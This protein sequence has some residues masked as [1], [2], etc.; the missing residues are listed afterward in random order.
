MRKLLPQV[1]EVSKIDSTV[2]L[3]LRVD[4]DIEY[5]KGHF[6]GFAILPGVALISWVSHFG[7]EYLG[8]PGVS[9]GLDAIKFLKPITPGSQVHL[10]I[11]YLKEKSALHFVCANDAEK[12]ASG[13]ILLGD[14]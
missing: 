8:A 7:V 13:R 6:D 10:E 14:S 9:M 12:V 5:F 1:L 11:E 2:R 4:E 3:V